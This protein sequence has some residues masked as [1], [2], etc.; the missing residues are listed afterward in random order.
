MNQPAHPSSLKKP[1]PGA[2]LDA[3]RALVSD[4][5]STSDAVRAHHGKDESAH[6]HAL[7]DAV[8]YAES[9]EEVSAIVKLCA[10][11]KVP[12][13]PFGAGS[14]VEGH[15]LAIHGGIALDLTHMNKVL[16]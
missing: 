8:V 2:L 15:V 9:T 4:R 7:P 13:I 12:L 1:L 5:V 14:S 3:L 6:P 16:A 11:H 10:Q